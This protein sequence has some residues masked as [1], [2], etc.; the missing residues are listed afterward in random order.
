MGE[1]QRCL[2]SH[3]A[4]LLLAHKIPRILAIRPTR[5]LCR[6]CAPCLEGK[7]VSCDV[8]GCTPLFGVNYSLTQGLDVEMRSPGP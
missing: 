3:R 8:I 2:F 7:V 1:L 6:W 4:T 5:R